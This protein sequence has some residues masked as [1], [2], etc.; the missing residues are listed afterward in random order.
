MIGHMGP[1]HHRLSIV[2]RAPTHGPHP[3]ELQSQPREQPM[4]SK[5]PAQISWFKW[6]VLWTVNDA[7][8]SLT[9]ALLGKVPALT[10]VPVTKLP[11]L[12]GIAEYSHKTDW[13]VMMREW[14]PIGICE[15]INEQARAY[16]D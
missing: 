8:D 15:A 5:R 1:K 2:T 9:N 13:R 16:L 3:I 6:H 4:I 14:G 11:M 12:L 10:L 7:R